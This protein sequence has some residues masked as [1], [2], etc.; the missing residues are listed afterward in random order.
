MVY[1]LIAKPGV[2]SVRVATG[3]T[4]YTFDKDGNIFK[5]TGER[6]DG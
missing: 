2:Y 3:G 4:V 5:S 1:Y 6:N